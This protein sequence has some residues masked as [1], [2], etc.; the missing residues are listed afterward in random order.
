MTTTTPL[1][2]R[3]GLAT[4]R[5]EKKRY[6][7]LLWAL[8]CLLVGMVLGGV[9]LRGTVAAGFIVEQRS[10]ESTL[11]SGD[12]VL[13]NRLATPARGDIVVM[14]GWGSGDTYVKRVI[15]MP[16]DTVEYEDGVFR[17]N[18]VVTPEPY[19]HG[20]KDTYSVEVPPGMLW[21]LGDNRAVSSDSRE[22]GFMPEDKVIGVVY[23]RYWPF[24]SVGVPG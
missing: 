14:D 8:P 11:E 15:G 7:F 24:T 20:E 1:P 9:V 10:M 5:R 21:V 16:G 13:A 22:H 4:K 6:R 18:G 23:F 17:L 2:T 19:A 3:K 12:A